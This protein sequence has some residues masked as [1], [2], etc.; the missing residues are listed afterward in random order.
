MF[1]TIRCE[2]CGGTW[3]VYPKLRELDP[4]RV[5]PHCD[6]RIDRLTWQK[7]ILP[8]FD[9]A[10]AANLELMRDHSEYHTPIFQVDF[11]ADSLFANRTNTDEY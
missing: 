4:A 2:A 7:Y 3:E 11:V 1:M 5:C 6:K 10:R 8:A 9:A